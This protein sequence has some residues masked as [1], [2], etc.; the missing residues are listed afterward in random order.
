MNSELS[1]CDWWSGLGQGYYSIAW[2]I[3]P[4]VFLMSLSEHGEMA[5]SASHSMYII[6]CTDLATSHFPSGWHSDACNV[7]VCHHGLHTQST[8][9]SHIPQIVQCMLW[10]LLVTWTDWNCWLYHKLTKLKRRW[11]WKFILVREANCIWRQLESKVAQ[12]IS[13]LHVILLIVTTDTGVNCLYSEED[14]A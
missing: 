8:I 10:L 3:L 14:G 5:A 6:M 4:L 7:S 12:T 13:Q 11:L 9:H 1:I 2:V